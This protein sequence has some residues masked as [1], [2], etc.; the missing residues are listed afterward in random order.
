MGKREKRREEKIEI[1]NLLIGEK[2][3]KKI[4]LEKLIIV[5]KGKKIGER[6]MGIIKRK[7]ER[8]GNKDNCL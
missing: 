6:L 8:E 1:K 5:K 2:L 7:I 3:I 4:G